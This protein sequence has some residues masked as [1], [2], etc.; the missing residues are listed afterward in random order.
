M[1]L[2]YLD[3]WEQKVG[4]KLRSDFKEELDVFERALD[5]LATCIS[6]LC[7]GRPDL[8]KKIAVEDYKTLDSETLGFYGTWILL[9]EALVRL[10]AARRLFLAGYLSRALASTRDALESAMTA[11]I[12]RN[13]ASQVKKWIRGKQI[14]LTD[15]YKYHP[16]LSWTIWKTAQ[17]ILNPLGTHSYMQASY[18][19]SL[20][21]LAILF[22]DNAEIQRRYKHD[23]QFVL[24]RMLIRCSQMLLYVK[25]VYP[26][27]KSQVKGFDATVAKIAVL[28]G[29]ELQ[30]PMDELLH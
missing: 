25:H 8:V 28:V 16:V 17:E 13:D 12:C 3:E 9:G 7:L 4:E 22:P 11:D 6:P 29:R 21:Q 10:K 23:G 1:V 26:K 2:D 15:D 19:S 30:I 5:N 14:K 20:P 24:H 27:A 18:L